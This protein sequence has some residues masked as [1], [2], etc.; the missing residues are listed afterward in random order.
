M[1]KDELQDFTSMLIKANCPPEAVARILALKKGEEIFFISS[2]IEVHNYL[3]AVG[4]D[5]YIEN[6]FFT[7][8]QYR[9]LLINNREVNPID[10]L[11]STYQA[12]D[13][14]LCNSLKSLKSEGF[15]FEDVQEITTH[16]TGRKMSSQSMVEISERLKN[17]NL[18]LINN[19]L[20]KITG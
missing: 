2:I 17:K 9:E 20:Y 6:E 3:T 16:L 8:N 7:S 18:S 11:I 10:F 13:E 1:K 12:V 4:I 15:S 19:K 14:R 5:E